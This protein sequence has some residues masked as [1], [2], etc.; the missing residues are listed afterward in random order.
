MTSQY[1]PGQLSLQAEQRHDF[2]RSA[3][4]FSLELTQILATMDTKKYH[5]LRAEA[6]AKELDLY[7]IEDFE[8][9]K[10][11][12]AAHVTDCIR[13][14]C[15]NGLPANITENYKKQAFVKIVAAQNHE[16]LTKMI[17]Q[18][19]EEL[20]S[21]YQKY[22]VN[23]YSY[24]IKRAIEYIQTQRFQPLSPGSVAE[25]LHVERTHLSKRF[26]KETGVTMTNYIHTMKMDLAEN[27]IQSRTYSLQEICDLLG[28]SNY[29][30]FC[31]LYKKYK[32]Y[33]PSQG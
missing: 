21:S 16:D 33:P 22:A 29:S 14:F 3:T 9:L 31:K 19:F 25:Y 24:L 4:L 20:S 10:L 6:F 32:K 17:D 8:I 1:L 2:L 27:M 13:A 5:E 26:H 7:I 18:L 28:Y 12:M 30:Y 15:K 11:Y 23:K